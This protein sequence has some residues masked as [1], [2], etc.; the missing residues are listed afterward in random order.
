MKG[1]GQRSFSTSSSTSF[2]FS[3]SSSSSSPHCKKERREIGNKSFCR[4]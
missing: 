2:S 1:D 3:S 4:V